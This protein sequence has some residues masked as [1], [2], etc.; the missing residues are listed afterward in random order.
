[1]T[2]KKSRWSTDE[3]VRIML[4]TFNPQTS[5]A[6]ICREHNLVP[7]TVYVWEEKFLAGGRS[8][9]DGPDASKQTLRPILFYGRAT[10]YYTMESTLQQTADGRSNHV[11][12]AGRTTTAPDEPRGAGQSVAGR[13]PDDIPA[14]F[15]DRRLSRE[16]G[17]GS[18]SQLTEILRHM[19]TR[20][21]PESVW[22]AVDGMLRDGRYVDDAD[23]L[24]SL[25]AGNEDAPSFDVRYGILYRLC[26]DDSVDVVVR[27]DALPYLSSLAFGRFEDGDPCRALYRIVENPA[28]LEELSQAV[29]TAGL[30]EGGLPH[31]RPLLRGV[32]LLKSKG[33]D[34]GRTLSS[35]LDLARIHGKAAVLASVRFMAGHECMPD[36]NRLVA[37]R[38][39][40][41]V[42]NA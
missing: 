33:A 31:F 40:R 14:L 28:M 27:S 10:Y 42:E 2:D 12:Y 21:P 23:R 34:Y 3:K 11:R 32:C 26:A 1:M 5:M 36:E 7:R 37:K 18:V 15:A 41:D 6:E 4:Q 38:L 22:G 29:I 24:A 16:G 13:T 8:S 35:A 30:A 9:L 25:F 19:E 17:D 39:L 20:F